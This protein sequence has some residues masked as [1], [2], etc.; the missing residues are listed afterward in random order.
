VE[1][2]T[3][4][5]LVLWTW[6]LGGTPLA[7]ALIQRAEEWLRDLA[8]ARAVARG[9]APRKRQVSDSSLLCLHG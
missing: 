4:D 1:V 7:L 6:V 8:R 3:M 2:M 5:E 9:S